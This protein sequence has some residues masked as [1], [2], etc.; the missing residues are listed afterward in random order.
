MSSD[1][2][3]F[4]ARDQTGTILG[5]MNSERQKRAGFQAFRWSDS[6]DERVRDSHRER[7]GKI[8]FML[9]IHYYQAKNIIVAV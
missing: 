4:I 7:N 5:Q 9:I 1:K 8:Y 3:A 2:A 6:G